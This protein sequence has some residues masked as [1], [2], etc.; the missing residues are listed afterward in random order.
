MQVAPI[1]KRRAMQRTRI[2]M[3]PE[4]PPSAV[5]LLG[6][7]IFSHISLERLTI[8]GFLPDLSPGSAGSNDGCVLPPGPEFTRAH[9]NAPIS[10]P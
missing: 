9:R 4:Y 1:S 6:M 3:P 8:T 7:L 2:H 5:A 10:A